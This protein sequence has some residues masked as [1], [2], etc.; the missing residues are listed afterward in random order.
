MITDL[1]LQRTQDKPL[2]SR[3]LSHAAAALIVW[4]LLIVV[5]T[6]LFEPAV[7]VVLVGPPSRM[8]QT[9][10]G[11][12][13][14]IVDAGRFYVR[15]RGTERGFVRALYANGAWLVIPA[16]IGG[17]IGLDPVQAGARK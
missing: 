11:T 9:L 3:W 14:R 12:D 4:C 6:A 8:L 16:S 1:E 7:D 15:V 2:P 17:C 5:I 10:D 13:S